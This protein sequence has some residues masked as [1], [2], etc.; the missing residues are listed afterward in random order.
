M[1][2]KNIHIPSFEE[3]ETMIQ[4]ELINLI[5]EKV[6][7]PQI[8]FWE[9]NERKDDDEIE[10]EFPTIYNL[11]V[12]IKQTS[13][14]NKHNEIKIVLGKD[15]SEALFGLDLPDKTIAFLKTYARSVAKVL[16]NYF[17][18]RDSLYLGKIRLDIITKDKENFI[19]PNLTLIQNI[20]LYNSVVKANM[21]HNRINEEDVDRIPYTEYVSSR[22]E[23]FFAE[24]RFSA[25]LQKHAQP[26]N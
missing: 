6:S 19:I 3:M 12:N 9:V 10:A 18:E 15:F 23:D 2:S 21:S 17:R 11:F 26:K 5:K 25:V 22:I 4:D 8:R 20:Y 13:K 14:K 7:H 1:S 16:S 24:L